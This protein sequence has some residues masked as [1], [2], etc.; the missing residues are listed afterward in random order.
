MVRIR[1]LVKAT[2]Y[3]K[4]QLQQGIYPSEVD[5]LQKF[6]LDSVETVEAICQ[7][8]QTSPLTL[9]TRS[10]QAYLYLK[11]IDWRNLP[12]T[13]QKKEISTATSLQTLHLKN[14]VKQQNKLQQQIQDLPPNYT[15][16]QL[17]TLRQVFLDFVQD[18]EEICHQNQVSPAVLATPSRKAYAWMKFLCDED[19]FK[20]HI[21]TVQKLQTLAHQMIT[22]Q[23][24]DFQEVQVTLTHSRH[25]YKCRQ[26]R[27]RILQLQLNEGFIMA[28]K[29]ILAAVVRAGL[30]G[31]N[32]EDQYQIRR[33]A[34]ME[35]YSEII[36][37]LDLIAEVDAENPQGSFY[38]LEA[39]F[40]RLNQE[41]FA[42]E[43]PKPRLTWNQILTHRKLGH[44]EPE[45]D[46]VVIS[47]TL[48]N[49]DVPSMVVE[50]VV[51]HELL[52]KQH[53]AKWVNGKRW[54]HTPEF[55]R[56]EQRFGYYQE[57]QQWLEQ[58]P[59]LLM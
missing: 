33:F 58:L 7:D 23:E 35:E 36:L 3:V 34:A 50:L 25:L 8:A 11:S 18:I 54:V 13:H 38:D 14:V 37:E 20:R 53:G 12:L 4:S 17:E 56:D 45:R 21:E 44:Y 28:D 46:R 32:P 39:L 49:P 19:Y 1:G 30:Q 9:P 55:R 40:D 31:K 27:S 41:Y 26:L 16:T 6:V 59:V 43:M 48:D 22:D 10:R 57:A 24:L 52:H 15:P 42:G 51:Y 2:N 47:Q 29:P 5:S